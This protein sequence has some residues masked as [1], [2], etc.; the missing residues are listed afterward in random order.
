MTTYSITKPKGKTLCK[1]S[2]FEIKEIFIKS[3]IDGMNEQYI[4]IP[5][6]QRD[7]NNDIIDSMLLTYT[8]D[9]ETFNYITNPLQLARL[10]INDIENIYLID[11]QHRYYM[12]EKLYNKKNINIKILV[13]IINCSSI[14]E[15]KLIFCNLNRDKPELLINKFSSTSV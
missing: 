9:N 6:F 8:K 3:L 10:K 15:I 1:S 13:N 4:I 12:Y 11:G 5:E 7:I 14:E 2:K